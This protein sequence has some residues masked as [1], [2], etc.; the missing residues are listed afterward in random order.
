MLE[1][2]SSRIDYD[3]QQ[4]IRWW[5]RT[6]SNGESALAFALRSKLDGDQRSRRIAANL[7]RLGLLQV[8]ALSNDPAKANFGLLLWAATRPS[9]YGDN[10]IKVILGCLGTAAVLETDRWDEALL[11]NI[12]G[13]FRTTGDLR[14]PRRLPATIPSSAQQGW[15]Y[16]RPR[17]TIHYAPH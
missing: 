10:D 4:P 17:P 3:G 1:G 15:Q 9:L 7:A 13:N 16:Y 2:V 14:L 11:K 8:R 5:L 12:L 6:D